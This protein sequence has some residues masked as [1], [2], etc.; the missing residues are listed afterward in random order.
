MNAETLSTGLA[1]GSALAVAALA[2]GAVT[3]MERRQIPNSISL[4]VAVTSLSLLAALPPAEAAAHVGLAVFM[5]LLGAVAFSFR[6]VG[7]GDVKL[8]AATMLWAGTALVSLVIVVMSLASV[9]IALLMLLSDQLFR[10][11]AGG[12][13]RG[14]TGSSGLKAPLPL[15]LAIAFGGVLAIMQRAAILPLG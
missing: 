5:F 8:F 6:L 11:P 2:I 15:G 3:D 1:I 13:A 12:I 9:A 10:R 4:L 7:G 14:P